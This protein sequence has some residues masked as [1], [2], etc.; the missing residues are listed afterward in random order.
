METTT[1][2]FWNKEMILKAAKAFNT[3]SEWQAGDS[4]SYGAAH[5][6]GLLDEAA[7]HMTRLR[8]AKGYWNATTV[9]ADAQKYTSKT[10]W[11]TKSFTAYRTAKFL[12]I[13]DRCTLHMDKYFKEFEQSV[14]ELK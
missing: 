7:K 2:I 9:F 13:F 5:R 10:E 1:H 6:M 4:R 12:K 3:R 14:G 8:M 11:N